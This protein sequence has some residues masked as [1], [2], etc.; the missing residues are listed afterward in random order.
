MSFSRCPRQGRGRPRGSMTMRPVATPVVYHVRAVTSA[1]SS[2]DSTTSGDVECRAH[3]LPRSG[4]LR[5]PRWRLAARTAPDT[6]RA[7]HAIKRRREAIGGRG[8]VG[9]MAG[10]GLA[11]GTS[12]NRRRSNST[13]CRLRPPPQVEVH[14]RRHNRRQRIVHAT[15]WRVLCVDALLRRHVADDEAM[16]HH[17]GMPRRNWSGS[18]GHRRC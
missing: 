16:R 9:G 7:A 4:G 8:S 5:C 2:M 14:L 3:P 13:S 6:P 10:M 1:R 12:G 18:L 17:I 11:A 15:R